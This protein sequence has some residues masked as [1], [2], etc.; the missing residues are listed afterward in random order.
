MNSNAVKECL[1][2]DILKKKLVMSSQACNDEKLNLVTS[3]SSYPSP[4]TMPQRFNL[5]EGNDKVEVVKAVVLKV[6][7]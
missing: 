5:S 2:V 1:Q 3:S 6:V 7:V 4:T